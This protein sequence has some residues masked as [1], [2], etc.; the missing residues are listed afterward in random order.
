MDGSDPGRA[1]ARLI[2]AQRWFALATGGDA[3][4]SPLLSY[5][6]FAV[7]GAAFGIVVSRLAAHTVH[8]LAG[9]AASVMLVDDDPQGDAYAQPR[10]S[11]GVS[12]RPQARASA[13]ADAIWSALQA[14]HGA[15]VGLLRTLPD[16]E[17]IALDPIAGRLVLGFASAHDLA[18]PAIA[19][20]L[21]ALAG[22]P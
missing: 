2:S 6:P 21:R 20:E 12:A 17:A 9:R 3:R 14:R 1:A 15:T 4:E 10:L 22:Q 19:K 5:V 7:V 11:I 18:G 16:F 8:L 13:P